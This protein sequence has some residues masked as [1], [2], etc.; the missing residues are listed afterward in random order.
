MLT[1]IFLYPEICISKSAIYI[2]GNAKS[3]PTLAEPSINVP[4]IAPINDAVHHAAYDI[5]NN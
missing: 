1:K 5:K 4:E 3:N 2:A